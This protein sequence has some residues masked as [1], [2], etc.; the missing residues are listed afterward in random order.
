M[1]YFLIILNYVDIYPIFIIFYLII[2]I[3][4]MYLSTSVSGGQKKASTP[5]KLEL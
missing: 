3:F 4:T 1:P 2:L 5:L